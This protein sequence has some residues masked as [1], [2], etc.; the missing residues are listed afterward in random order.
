M[1]TTVRIA[2]EDRDRLLRVQSRLTDLAGQHL[3]LQDIVGRMVQHAEAEPEH[4][5]LDAWK[6]M[7]PAE[8]TS[9]DARIAALGGWTG[10][11]QDIDAIVYD[12][13]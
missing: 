7:T 3:S 4:I 12:E 13:P 2:K 10:S 11:W 5:L 6:P 9:Q 8:R 1:S